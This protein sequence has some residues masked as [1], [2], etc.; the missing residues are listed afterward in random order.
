[1]LRIANRRAVL[2]LVAGVAV[3]GFTLSRLADAGV[4]E[5]LGALVVDLPGWKAAEPKVMSVTAPQ[6]TMH[7]ATRRYTKDKA[8]LSAMLAMTS[9]VELPKAQE[10]QFDTPKVK[11]VAKQ[12]DGF[13]TSLTFD[14]QKKAGTFLVWLGKGPKVGGM[15]TL[16]FKGVDDKEALAAAKTFDW[17]KMKAKLD[18]LNK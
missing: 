8:E 5:D 14:K 12:M 9:N 3:G 4:G 17:K 1:M 16:S 15:L 11:F 6:M 18:A 10:A 7:H 2:W 13:M